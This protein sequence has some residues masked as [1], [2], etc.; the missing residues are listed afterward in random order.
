VTDRRLPK[1]RELAP[2]LSPRGV[3]LSPTGRRLAY[4]ASITDLREAARKRAPRAVFDYT[5]GA[6]GDE[7]TLARMRAAYRG[8]EFRPG[9]LRDVSAVDPSTP[10]VGTRSALPLV[11]APTGFT[12]MMHTDGEPAVGRVAGRAGIPYALSTLGTTSIE[13]LAEQAPGTRLWFQLYLWRDRVASQ[14]FVT[15]AADAGYEALVLTVDTPV[16]GPRLRDVR[17]GMTLP[18]TLTLRTFLDGA[19]HPAWWLDLLT[20]RP[21]EF[22][23]LTRFD[24]TVAQLAAKMFDPSATF[25]DLEWLR[26]LWK[27][28]LLVKGVQTESDAKAVVDAGADA[29]IVSNHGGRQLDRS[30]VPLLQLPAILDAVGERAEVYIDGGVLSGADVVAAVALG[31]R[32]V[33][34]G[35]AYLYGLMAGGERGVQKAYDILSAEIRSTMALLGVSTIAGLRPDHVRILCADMPAIRADAL[36]RSGSGSG[37]THY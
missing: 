16:A 10:L 25:A 7:V 4:A 26:G 31:A 22:A 35:R 18:P 3:P 5:D 30:P 9:V 14:D 2:L 12:R 15:R 37:P 13:D 34:V 21:L 19:T 33:L 6:A 8:I 27:G 17:N 20:T 29:V 36:V 1:W 23:S 24:G 28:P 11:F 32:G